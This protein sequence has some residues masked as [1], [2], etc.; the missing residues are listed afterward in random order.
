MNPSLK[1]SLLLALALALH[2]VPST[3]TAAL[4][5]TEQPPLFALE[6]EPVEMKRSDFLLDATQHIEKGDQP[7]AYKA[8]SL[9]QAALQQ[10]PLRSDSDLAL[11]LLLNIANGQRGGTPFERLQ[12]GSTFVF[13]TQGQQPLSP[14][15][16]PASLW[17]FLMGA[18][19]LLGAR[20]SGITGQRLRG[21][22]EGVGAIRRL[23]A[24]TA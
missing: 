6:R 2:C 7:R 15:P 20:I 8:S 23:D 21:E 4:V 13:E 11:Y 14:V 3:S 16:L 1:P 24:A 9:A 17:L 19:G 12:E 5:S 22:R 18:M 10:L